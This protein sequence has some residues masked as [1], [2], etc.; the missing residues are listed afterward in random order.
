MVSQYNTGSAVIRFISKNPNSGPN[1][2]IH[3]KFLVSLLLLRWAITLSEHA[4]EEC[5]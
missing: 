2:Y 3:A 1:N 4:A 5:S